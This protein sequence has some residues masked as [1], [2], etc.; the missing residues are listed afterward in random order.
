GLS[1]MITIP[2]TVVRQFRA[3]LRRALP[4]VSRADSPLLLC[5]AGPEGLMLQAKQEDVALRYHET[6]AQPPAVLAFRSSLLAQFEGRTDDPVTV[7]Q[8]DPKKARAQ[9]SEGTE[10]HAIEL[11]T[12]TPDDFPPLPDP[13]K[14]FVPMP[15]NFLPALVDAGRTTKG[16]T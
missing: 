11:E 13:P 4:G 16:Q 9:W 1:T 8:L 10:N 15:P 3:V 7:E 12:A 6:G 5:R 2:R 14:R